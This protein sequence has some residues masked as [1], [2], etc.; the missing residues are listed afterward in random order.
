MDEVFLIGL[1]AGAFRFATPIALAA[2]GETIAQRSGVLNV[3]IEGIMLVGAFFAV[4]GSVWTGTPYG[5]LACAIASGIAMAG[6]HA[7]LSITLKVDQIVSGIA[8]I[9]LGLGFSGFFYRLTIGAQSR[10]PAVPTFD[11][12]NLGW[13]SELPIIGP[14]LFQH[15]LLVYAP[16][17]IALLL[18]WWLYR[19]GPGLQVRATGENPAAAEAA[20]VSVERVRY[21]CVLFGGAMAGLAGAYLSTA[22]LSGFVENMVSG[23]GFIAVACVVFGRWN[24]IGA[25]L[26]ALFFGAADAAQIRLQILNP[27]IPFELFVMMPYVLAV[28]FLIFFAGRA[29][30][31]AAL[32]IPFTGRF[33]N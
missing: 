20:G 15:H 3:G 8:L 1:L 23:R 6:L 12:V 18:W 32:G 2:L 10:A 5:G 17:V 4:L 16:V 33:R 19:T 25:A 9:V 29:Q 31:P 21:G 27:D 14:V 26:A 13:I 30:M 24:P 7:F 22:Q 11:K 28:L